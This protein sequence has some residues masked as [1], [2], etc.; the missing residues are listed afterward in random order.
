MRRDAIT[1]KKRKR[2]ECVRYD[3]NVTQSL[4]VLA[5]GLCVPQVGAAGWLTP[6]VRKRGCARTGTPFH[7]EME[8]DLE[9]DLELESVLD[10][11]LKTQP[12]CNLERKSK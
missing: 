11:V 7:F 2:K 3:Q 12:K 5:R 6:S 9:F 8:T 1:H 10:L 4:S